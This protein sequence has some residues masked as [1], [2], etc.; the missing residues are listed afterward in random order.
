V[1]A[2]LDFYGTQISIRGGRVLVPGGKQSELAWKELAGAS[3]ENPGEFIPK[4]LAKDEGWLASYFDVL[5]RLNRSQQAYFAE[6]HRLSHFYEALRGN[7]ISPSPARPVFRPEP[8]LLLMT[9]L[10]EIEP[11]GQPHIPGGA[12]V[13]KEIVASH[14]K[15]G[16]KITKEWA[17]RANH[18]NSPEQVAE[19]MVGLSRV[20]GAGSPLQVFLAVSEIDAGKAGGERL[21]P[22]TVKLL[23]DRFSRFGDQYAIFSEFSGL[24]NTSITRYLSAAEAINKI[25]DHAVRGNAMGIFQANVGLWEILDRQGE[26]PAAN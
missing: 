11:G 7:D 14:R 12:D 15:D 5:S 1:T 16:S 6:P 19:G 25:S 4:L 18:W 21:T 8:G 10:L 22:Q 23:A 2:A 13:W 20:N 26:I 17:K 3:P 24:N 9:T